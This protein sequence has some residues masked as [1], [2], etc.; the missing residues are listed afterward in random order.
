MLK[1]VWQRIFQNYI[2]RCGKGIEYWNKKNYL[3]ALFKKTQNRMLKK[4]NKEFFKTTFSDEEKEE[5]SE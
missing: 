5:S 3:R 1:K 2:F 4:Y